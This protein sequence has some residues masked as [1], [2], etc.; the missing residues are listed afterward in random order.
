MP[1]GELICPGW[2]FDVEILRRAR[3][4]GLTIVE[5]PVTWIIDGRSKMQYSHMFL[6]LWDS[7]AI[8]WR[9]YKS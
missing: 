2:A 4:H 5:V 9:T 6:M 3:I 1:F 8:A 7:I